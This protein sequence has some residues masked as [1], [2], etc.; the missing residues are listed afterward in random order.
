MSA[1][2]L[3]KTFASPNGFLVEK[4][5]NFGNSETSDRDGNIYILG[6]VTVQNIVNT[7]IAKY[8]S[9]GVL[10]KS[11]GNGGYLYITL[12]AEYICSGV[13]ITLDN[14]DKLVI[15]GTLDIELFIA[16][17]EL[18]GT[19]DLT[20]NNSGF[21]TQNFNNGNNSFGFFITIDNNNNIVA[22]G[23]SEK[24]GPNN[25]CLVRY[26]ND[27]TI[28][29]SFSGVG[30]LT[31][32]FNTDRFTI[33]YS[34]TVDIDN[35]IIVSGLNID[36]NNLQNGLIARFLNNGDLDESFNT[37]GYLITTFGFDSA[38]SIVGVI[39]YADKIFVTGSI[40]DKLL[41]AKFNND[42]KLDGSFN[43][44]GYLI[45]DFGFSGKIAVGV[46]I[47]FD[48]S[49]RMV[50]SGTANKTKMLLARYNIDGTLDKSFNGSGFLVN[51][52]SFSSYN[53]NVGNKIILDSL[54][55]ITI[56][57]FGTDSLGNVI[58]I[59]ARY[60]GY[61]TEPICLPAGTPINTDQGIIA[62]EM[63]DTK[64]HT[65]GN[66]PIIA[67]TKTIT[68]EKYLVCFDKFTL[69]MN[70]PSQRTI[71]TPCHQVLYKGNLVQAKDFL[72]RIEGINAIKYNG[73]VLYNVLQEKHG[74]MRVNNMI[75]ETLHPENKVAREILKKL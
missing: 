56:L 74:L 39:T 51:D 54:D 21:V 67:I 29:T 31:T 34:V 13:C 66:K 1:G 17:F 16:R 40:D 70:I 63:I 35:N 2:T 18:D 42:G 49:D 36:V 60:I 23:F 9:S 73:Q 47:N 5:I 69:G 45:S 28:D 65:I 41:I 57:A 26:R 48:N 33:G 72:A 12:G 62:I 19:P 52:F 75:L 46:T 22:T 44:T 15:T 4:M 37:T 27:G 61:T 50:I 53:F 64:I 24:M 68:P 10:D 7:V 38:C 55:N 43:N 59:V 11:F 30:Y 14:N 71:M 58:N 25:L 32:T 6:N 20:F 8:N 3:D